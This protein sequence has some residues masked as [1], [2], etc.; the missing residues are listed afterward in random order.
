MDQTELP[1]K[2]MQVSMAESQQIIMVEAARQPCQ[3]Q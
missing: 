1:S 2:K 3:G